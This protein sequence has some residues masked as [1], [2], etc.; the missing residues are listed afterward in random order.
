MPQM[1]GA[2]LAK[3]VRADR[4]DLPVMLITGYTGATEQDYG[5]PRL[6]PSPSACS[7]WRRR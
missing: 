4:P 7:N 3:R 1:D 5:L 6:C 2:A